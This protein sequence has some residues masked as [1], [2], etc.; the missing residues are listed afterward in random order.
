MPE[1]W[2]LEIANALLVAERRRRMR[3]KDIERAINDLAA[4]PITIDQETHQRALK[5]TFSLASKYKLSSY[6]A[7]YLELA[8]R[9]RSPL[10]TLDKKLRSAC[11]AAGI[12]LL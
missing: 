10:A 7:A 1:I 11:R 12:E 2:P 4:L 9:T 5:A 6:D 8:Q 3:E